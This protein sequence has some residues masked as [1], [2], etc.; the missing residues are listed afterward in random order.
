MIAS[1]CLGLEENAGICTVT[2]E[3][4][5]ALTERGRVFFSPP[6]ILHSNNTTFKHPNLTTTHHNGTSRRQTPSPIPRS[7]YL[8]PRTLRP[9]AIPC[10]YHPSLPP[11]NLTTPGPK[12][13]LPSPPSLRSLRRRKENPHRRNPQR[14]LRA[15]RREDKDR[16][17]CLPNDLQP[18][19]RIQHRVLRLPPRNHALRR[20]ELRQSS[21]SRPS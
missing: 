1:T 10:T 16:L 18:Q 14:T 17:P 8:P 9:S 21:S 3:A 2:W 7:T 15:R 6:R 19:T 13:R 4:L 12:W 5:Y 20:R 11:I